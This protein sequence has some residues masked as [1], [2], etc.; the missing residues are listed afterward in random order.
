MRK[1]I[2][3]KTQLQNGY[4]FF[5]FRKEFHRIFIYRAARNVYNK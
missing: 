4:S 2:S 3:M 5:L 1:N